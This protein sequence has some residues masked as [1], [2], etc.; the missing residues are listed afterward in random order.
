M[1]DKLKANFLKQGSSIS[2]NQDLSIVIPFCGFFNKLLQIYNTDR[3]VLVLEA[4]SR[5]TQSKT[6]D[7]KKEDFKMGGNW[8]RKFYYIACSL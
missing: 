4:A 3:Q 5:C 2:K 8:P 6:K 7:R 1:P